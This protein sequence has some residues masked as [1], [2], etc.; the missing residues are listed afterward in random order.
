MLPFDW[1]GFCLLF[2]PFQSV[3]LL[4]L[5]LFLFCFE[6]DYNYFVPEG[7]CDSTEEET[8]RRPFKGLVQ[9]ERERERERMEENKT[10]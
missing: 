3:S 5:F 8:A 10:K 6:N 9:R 1:S 4:F 2:S 7:S